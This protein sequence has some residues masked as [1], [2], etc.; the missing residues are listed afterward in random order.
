[1]TNKKQ[2]NQPP[3]WIDKLLEW[4]CS[5]RFIDEV[6]GDLHEWFSKRVEEQGLRKA[7]AFYFLDVIS[8]IRLFRLKNLKEMEGK[9]NKLFINYLVVAVRHFK[10]NFWYSSL[11]A[12]G[13]TIAL[14]STLLI[15]VYILDELSFDRFHSDYEIT[16]RLVNHSPMQGMKWASTPSPWKEH[17]T[18]EIPEIA[19]HTRLGQDNILVLKENQKVFEERFYWADDNLL[20]FFDFETISGNPQSMLLEPNSVVIT[21][22]KAIQYFNRVD[23]IGEMLPLKVYDGDQ[24]FLMQVTGVLE[25]IPSNSHLQ[26]DFLGSMSSTEEM[27]GRFKT[28]WGL[29]WLHSYVKIGN[30]VDLENVRAKLPQMFEKHRGE[31]SSEYSDIIFQPLKDVRLYSNDIEGPIQRGNLDYLLLFGFVAVLIL[32]AAIINYVNLTTA[33]SNQRGKEVSIRK[34]FGAKRGQISR[35]FY[36]ECAF[37]LTIA[38]AFAYVLAALALPAFNTLVLKSLT[39][40][41]FLSL[42]VST[43]MITVSIVILSFS[44][45]YPALLMNRFRPI[46]ILRGVSQKVFGSNSTMRNGQ[47]LVQFVI[48]TFLIGSTVVVLNQMRFLNKFDKGF[49]DEQLIN[50]PVDDRSMQAQLMVI[51]Q[52]LKDIPGIAAITTSGEALPSAM[53]NTSSFNWPGKDT[54]QAPSIHTVAIDYDYFETLESNITLGRDLSQQYASDST[55]VC[56]IN[57]SAFNKTGWNDLIDKEIIIDNSRRKV[58]GVVEDFHYNSLHQGVFPVAYFLVPPGYRTS[59]DNLI[60]R[61]NPSNFTET[62]NAIDKVWSDFSQQPLEFSF[63]DQSFNRLY[64]DEQRFTRLVLSF[65]AIGIFLAVLGLLGLVSFVTAKRSKEISIRKVLGARSRQ[66]IAIVGK[67]FLWIAFVGIVVALP[68]CWYVMTQWLSRF[69]YAIKV[70]WI[71]FIVSAIGAASIVVL[72]VGSKA[73]KVANANPTKYLRD[74]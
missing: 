18:N 25:D 30:D 38:L 68:V 67:Q 35:Q 66:L 19:D 9:N 3:K 16:Y 49:S 37:Q 62:T 50:I 23:V 27:Y 52:R 71:V 32:I 31:G 36:V 69:E 45:L 14:L 65:S 44:G 63:V 34:V 54:D 48:A 15:S 12:F 47:V 41:S 26:F 8:Y 64:G 17:M 7:K 33:K 72:T 29:N 21:K 42:E 6:Q 24:E 53:N 60:V 40:S 20:T 39:V 1:L 46:D 74:Q 61:V 5:P 43:V 59:P 51:K 56:V 55:M 2:I 10:K 22:S 4:Y 57:Q 70:D 73:F 28:W 11:N 13:L 58:V